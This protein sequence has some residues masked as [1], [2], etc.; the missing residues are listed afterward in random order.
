MDA[1]ERPLNH[2][3]YKSLNF[4]RAVKI[5]RAR[6][7]DGGGPAIQLPRPCPAPCGGQIGCSSRVVL[8][9]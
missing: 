7:E 5:M 8:I 9:E 2:R 6:L 1:A 4:M 3:C